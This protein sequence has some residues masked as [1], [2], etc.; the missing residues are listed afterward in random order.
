MR[1]CT[2]TCVCVRRKTRSN[3]ES[4]SLRADQMDTMSK[5]V[6]ECQLFSESPFSR[7]RLL[8]LDA[9]SIFTLH[10]SLDRVIGGY[11]L[12]FTRQTVTEEWNG[13]ERE[14]EKKMNAADYAVKR[15]HL[16]CVQIGS[17]SSCSSIRSLVRSFVFSRFFIIIIG[18]ISMEINSKT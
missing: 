12:H 16:K 11:G 3:N 4:Y 18:S 9:T 6:F 13:R 1:T 5:T 14:K 7:V 17:S 2:H 10:S 8:T 15:E